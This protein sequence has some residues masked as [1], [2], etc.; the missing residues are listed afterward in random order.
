MQDGRRSVRYAVV[1]ALSKTGR[2]EAKAELMTVAAKH[3]DPLQNAA[4]Y[5]LAEFADEDVVEFFDK[6]LE[7]N[8][9]QISSSIIYALGAMGTSHSEALIA[10]LCKSDDPRIRSLALSNMSATDDLETRLSS[11]KSPRPAIRRAPPRRPG[12]WV[13]RGPNRP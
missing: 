7:Q 13:S 3:N 12:P 11:W 9:W 2:S 10:D 1:K 4:I 5:A 8:Q 6:L